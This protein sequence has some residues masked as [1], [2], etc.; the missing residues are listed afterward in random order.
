[1]KRHPA[2]QELSRDHHQALVV[3]RQ[4]KR[5]DAHDAEG[6]RAVFLDYWERDGRNHFRDEEEILLPTLARFTE[7]HQPV[8]AGVLIDH[9]RI[10]S[11]ADELA[12]D[13]TIASLHALGEEL[14][15][16]VRRE[17]REL[18][19]LLERTIPEAELIKLAQLLGSERRSSTS[20][21]SGAGEV[22]RGSDSG[23]SASV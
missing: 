6:A 12:G 19:P 14:E 18:F 11:R 16:H 3:A 15:R 9:V 8:V 23:T 5:A 2:L 17:E 1:M 10:R 4:L 20:H 13:A 7:P 21:G 22:R